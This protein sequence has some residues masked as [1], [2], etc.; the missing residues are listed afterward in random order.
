METFPPRVLD[1]GALAVRRES[2]T[3]DKDCE[4]PI[5]VAVEAVGE[6]AQG[7]VWKEK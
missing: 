1:P 2:Q 7:S 4:S 5:E 3:E 6:I